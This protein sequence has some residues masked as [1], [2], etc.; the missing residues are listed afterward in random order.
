MYK[1]EQHLEFRI[2]R[3]DDPEVLVLIFKRPETNNK[4]PK[5]VSMFTV[6]AYTPEDDLSE[7]DMAIFLRYALLV[8]NQIEFAELFKNLKTIVK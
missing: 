6:Y 3:P 1:G 5:L 7:E 2:E 4:A 8:K